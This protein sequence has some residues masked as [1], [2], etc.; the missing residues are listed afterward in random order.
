MLEFD[1]CYVRLVIYCS[2]LNQKKEDK[3]KHEKK[4]EAMPI[5]ETKKKIDY[6]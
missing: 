4:L 6:K 3:M 1:V 5:N 2:F